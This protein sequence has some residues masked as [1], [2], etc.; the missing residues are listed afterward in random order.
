M[1]EYSI[2]IPAFNEED[3]L[4]KT[5]AAVRAAMEQVPHEGELLVVDNNS[6]DRTA[7]IA[8]D[9]G[10]DKVIFESHNQ[11]AKARNSG[12]SESSAPFLIFVDA[13]TFP[14]A[15]ILRHAL[16]LLY[17]NEIVGGGARVEMEREVSPIVAWITHNWNFVSRRLNYAAGSFFFCR[18]D[19]FEAVGGFDLSVYA[20]EEIWLARRL[21][22]WAKRRG[23][24]FEVVHELSVVT[25]ARKSD[26]FSTWDFVRQIG[27]FFIFPW[28]T[29]SKR[30]CNLWY[31]RPS[32]NRST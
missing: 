28:A 13:D 29:K 20:G 2:I 16:T 8:Y 1:P 12:A 6:T 11:I 3:Y 10:A 30:L 25:S 5:L 21:K 17:S 19:A 31:K 7:E 32:E 4:G 26:W 27:L 18:R 14:S 22:A 24:K 9:Q 15:A 23:M